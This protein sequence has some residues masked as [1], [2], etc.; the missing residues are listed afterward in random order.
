MI[1]ISD[2]NPSFD[3][4]V[5]KVPTTHLTSI[6]P[7]AVLHIHINNIINYY[8]VVKYKQIIIPSLTYDFSHIIYLCFKLYIF[9]SF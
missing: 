7:L 8:T 2:Q 5:G 1:N 9:S 6:R 3:I 4:F